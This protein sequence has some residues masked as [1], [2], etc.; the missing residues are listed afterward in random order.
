LITGKAE[1][2]TTAGFFPAVFLN[3]RGGGRRVL[4]KKGVVRYADHAI[5]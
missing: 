1:E 3:V 2:I 5:N 4:K